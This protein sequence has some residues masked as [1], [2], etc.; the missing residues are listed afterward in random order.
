MDDSEINWNVDMEVNLF[1][2]IRHHKPVGV[3]RFFQM[4]FI[5]DKLNAAHSG[6]K[7][8]TCKQIWGHLSQMYDLQALNESENFPFPNKASEFTLPEEYSSLMQKSFPRLESSTT[9]QD[10]KPDAKNVK[11]EAKSNVS[12]H[13]T[14]S[15]S[16]SSSSQKTDSKP[17]SSQKTESKSSGT[18]HSKDH[19]GSSVL[20]GSKS[21]SKTSLSGHWS[22][23]N[24]PDPSPKRKRTRQTQS[25]SA[26][27]A[28]PDQPPIK[29]GRR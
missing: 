19:K 28:T 17:S 29:R 20:H 10:D 18:P 16:K 26:S 23:A 13:T 14:K 15:E 12:S 25:A 1:H 4:I 2:A 21:E 9:H 5:H 27:P 6:L 3:N 11:A 24:T 7:T 8:F 22:A